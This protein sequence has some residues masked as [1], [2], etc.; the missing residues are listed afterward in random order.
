M[1]DLEVA[2][3]KAEVHGS[4]MTESGTEAEGT[5]NDERIK[6][7]KSISLQSQDSHFSII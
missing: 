4:G 3:Q 5:A 7:S 6:H 1:Y 2:H